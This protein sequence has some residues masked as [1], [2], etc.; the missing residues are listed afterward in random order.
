[1]DWTVLCAEDPVKLV[2][3][4]RQFTKGR[5]IIES[6]SGTHCKT[7]QPLFYINYKVIEASM[8]GMED[9]VQ[10]NIEYGE[11]LTVPPQFTREITVLKGETP[12]DLIKELK[13]F[14]K[15]RKITKIQFGFDRGAKQSIVYV[16]YEVVDIASLVIDDPVG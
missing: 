15:G 11:E 16:S 10:V 8:V 5:V 12:E 6:F 3:L 1:M 13:R 7:K 4:R 2:E 9:P 14:H